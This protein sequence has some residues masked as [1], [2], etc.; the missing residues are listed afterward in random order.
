M[1]FFLLMNVLIISCIADGSGIDMLR[2]HKINLKR[3]Y[4]KR[5]YIRKTI[6]K[7]GKLVLQKNKKINYIYLPDGMYI[8]GYYYDEYSVGYYCYGSLCKQL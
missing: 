7:N 8:Y 4:V 3:V 1:K 5:T 6:I 2:K